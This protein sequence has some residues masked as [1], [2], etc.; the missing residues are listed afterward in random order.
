MQKSDKNWRLHKMQKQQPVRNWRFR[1]M[2]KPVRNWRFRQITYL[3]D[4]HSRYWGKYQYLYEEMKRKEFISSPYLLNICINNRWINS[5]KKKKE[6]YYCGCCVI[7]YSLMSPL[8]KYTYVIS[9]YRIER[10]GRRC[11]ICKLTFKEVY[12]LIVEFKKKS[13]WKKLIIEHGRLIVFK[14]NP[15]S[16]IE[17]DI[18]NRFTKTR[19]KELLLIGVQLGIPNDVWISKI[20]PLVID[21]HWNHR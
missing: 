15:W 12:D 21:T 4:Y 7:P 3:P 20:L 13:N 16:L 19:V 11:C 6:V 10:T 2:R 17:W 8:L 14:R 1:K 5:D 9:T 18:S